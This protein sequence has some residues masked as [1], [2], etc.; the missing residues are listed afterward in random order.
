MCHFFLY[1]MSGWVFVGVLFH[2]DISFMFIRK[3]DLYF[4]FSPLNYLGSYLHQCYVSLQVSGH[5]EITGCLVLCNSSP[6]PNMTAIVYKMKMLSLETWWTLPVKPH[7]C[8]AT[9]LGWLSSQYQISWLIFLF[10]LG[11]FVFAFCFVVCL[12]L[13]RVSAMYLWMSWN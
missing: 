12:F 8:G 10:L 6:P 7:G 2:L 3:T 1:L 9:I 5:S 13:D 4:F 11:F